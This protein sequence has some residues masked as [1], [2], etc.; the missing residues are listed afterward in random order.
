MIQT[1]LDGMPGSARDFLNNFAGRRNMALR[2]K[3]GTDLLA[4]VMRDNE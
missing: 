4:Q 2:S 1:T 3:V